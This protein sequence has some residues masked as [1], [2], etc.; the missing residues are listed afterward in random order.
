MFVHV[1][2]FSLRL[3]FPDFHIQCCA[4]FLGLVRCGETYVGYQKLFLD[5]A[6]DGAVLVHLFSQ[7]GRQAQP[8]AK[9]TEMVQNLGISNMDHARDLA[10]K[11]DLLWSKDDG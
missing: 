2:V 10:T 8:L 6:V 5:H 3:L 9:I 4:L 1:H 7:N 11:I